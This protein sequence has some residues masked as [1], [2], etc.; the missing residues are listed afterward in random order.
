VA[1]CVPFSHTSARGMT[2]ARCST[3]CSPVP[4]L[5]VNVDRYHQ[6][7]LNWLASTFFMFVDVKTLGY[8]PFSTRPAMTVERGATDSQPLAA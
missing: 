7:R 4:P 6:S 1:I 5:T 2:P 3:V 8:L